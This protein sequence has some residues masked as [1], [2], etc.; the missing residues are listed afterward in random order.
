M[1]KLVIIGAN[2]FQLPL[3]VKAREMGY[4][5]HVFSWSRKDA[6][7]AKA[8]AFYEISI[9]EKERILEKC[10]EICP[11]AVAT[12][13]SDLANVTVAYL[14][15]E[16]GLPGN[17]P[18]CVFRST[19][20]AAMRSAFLQAGIPVPFFKKVACAEDISR[21]ELAYPV[22]VKPTDRSG[23]R[24]ITK[25]ERPSQ[26]ASAIREAIEQSFEKQAI[27]EGYIEGQEYSMETISFEGRHT[28]LAVTKKFTTGE[29]H[30]IEVGHLEPAPISEKQRESAVDM[31]FRGLDA[32]GVKSG[33]SHAEF[34]IDGR[35]RVRIIEIGSRMGGDCIGSHLV[36][37][38][39]G[40]DYVRMVIDTAFGHSPVFCS[41]PLH[42]CSAIRFIMEKRDMDYLEKVK[43]NYP[44]CLRETRLTDI[45]GSHA[46]VDSGSRFGYYILQTDTMQEMKEILAEDSGLFTDCSFC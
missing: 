32:L 35:G 23:S 27:V 16:L 38:S 4:E 45:P 25:V 42:K 12:I 9:T 22:I 3:I 46:V 34:R 39:A 43:K 33:A 31:V 36:S 28:C 1:K 21:E 30:F 15:K 40:E 2:E 17:S 5:T 14:A 19:N 26:L 29:P 44:D 24:A 37:L 11:D 18:E 20:K 41:E 6:G 7:A 8:D 10:R 13:G